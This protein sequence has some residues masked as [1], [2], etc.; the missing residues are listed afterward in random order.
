M[1]GSVYYMHW[2]WRNCPS[3]WKGMF[4]GRGKH[5]T[6]ILEAVVSYDLWIWHAYFGMP[7]SCN[8]INILHRSNLF[9]RHLSGDTPNLSHTYNMG[10]YLAY[11]IYPNW[12]A[13]VKTIRNPYD[14]RTQ[15]FV[16]IQE[17]ARKDN[18]RTF[19]A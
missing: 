13:F 12:P 1:L 4:T 10:Y 6:M 17:P 9:E 11:G 15:H 18:E 19:G 2:E 14:V 3:A 5:P 7:G 8:D 16:T